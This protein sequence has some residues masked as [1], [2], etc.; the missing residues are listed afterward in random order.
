MHVLS[1]G[2]YFNVYRAFSFFTNFDIFCIDNA[3]VI[4]RKIRYFFLSHTIIPADLFHPS[5]SPH[6]KSFQ[7]FS[8]INSCASNVHFTSFFLNLFPIF[9]LKESYSCCIE[10]LDI[11]SCVNLASYFATQMPHFI[12]VFSNCHYISVLSVCLLHCHSLYISHYI[13]VLSTKGSLCCISVH[14]CFIRLQ[15]SPWVVYYIFVVFMSHQF[16]VLSMYASLHCACH[17]ICLSTLHFST[18]VLH[19]VVLLSINT[20]FPGP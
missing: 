18:Y 8:T 6:F 12:A 13:A 7:V 2:K 15:P 16:G 4:Y 11:I 17:H 14:E 3:R 5:P 20:V 1:I 19:H 9:W 10:I